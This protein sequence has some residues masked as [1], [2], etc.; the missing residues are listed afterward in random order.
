M[1]MSFVKS[2]WSKKGSFAGW[3]LSSPNAWETEGF[4]VFLVSTFWRSQNQVHWA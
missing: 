1:E 2:D 3:Y 4:S